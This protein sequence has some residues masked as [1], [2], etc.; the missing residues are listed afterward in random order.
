[1]NI[2]DMHSITMMHSPS[3]LTETYHAKRTLRSS[4]YTCTHRSMRHMPTAACELPHCTAQQFPTFVLPRQMV[5]NGTYQHACG[6]RSGVSLKCAQRAKWIIWCGNVNACIVLE[7]LRYY[8]V[9][10]RIVH[11]APRHPRSAHSSRFKSCIGTQVLPSSY[12]MTSHRLACIQIHTCIHTLICNMLVPMHIN[13]RFYRRPKTT[14]VPRW[15][16]KS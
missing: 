11:D 16:Q 13:I 2:Q 15:N 8:R 7:L 14:C 12:R 9:I 5:V 4:L 10:R 1:M 3:T 6:G